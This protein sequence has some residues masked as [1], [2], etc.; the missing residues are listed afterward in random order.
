MNC[1]K[2]NRH[3]RLSEPPV[4]SLRVNAIAFIQYV[5]GNSRQL[6]I[7][8]LSL[9]LGSLIDESKEKTD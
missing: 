7:R 6:D 5:E 2:M 9:V 8:R 3:L 4:L 1:R